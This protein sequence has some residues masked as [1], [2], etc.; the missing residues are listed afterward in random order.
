MRYN[1]INVQTI[2][3]R[4]R[5]VDAGAHLSFLIFAHALRRADGLG[6]HGRTRPYSCGL[7][8]RAQ[9]RLPA[10]SRAPPAREGARHAPGASSGPELS[11]DKRRLAKP[12]ERAVGYGR[13]I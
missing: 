5:L 12:G 10:E 9:S 4:V 8:L 3:I 6:H 13:Q 1:E 7:R 11:D 2:V